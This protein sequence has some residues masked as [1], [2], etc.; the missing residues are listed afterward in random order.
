MSDSA[1]GLIELC[2]RHGIG[3]AELLGA[4]QKHAEGHRRSHESPEQAFARR[5]PAPIRGSQA[6]MR[7]WPPTTNWNNSGNR[8]EMRQPHCRARFV[9]Q[10]TADGDGDSRGWLRE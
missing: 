3:A 6:G 4:M 1:D 5:S 10:L 8:A 9:L 7:F 2:K